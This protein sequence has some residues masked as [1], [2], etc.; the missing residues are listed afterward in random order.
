MSTSPPRAGRGRA[1]GR[2]VRVSRRA[3][4]WF[5]AAAFAVTMVGT[6]LPT[7]LYVLY[8]REMGFSTL[9]TTVVFAT[10]A[11]GVLAALLLFGRLSDAIGRRRTLLPGLA[12]A[13][14]SAVV[15]LAAHD[16]TL[17]LLGRLLSGLSAG[18]FTGTATAAL[19][20]LADDD[21][22]ERATLVSTV[23]NMGGL[24]TGPLLAGVLA[25][26]TAA[27]LITPFAV[28]LV[29]LVLAAAGI[30]LIPETVTTVGRPRLSFARPTVPR[31]MRGTF[32]RS[33]TAGFAGFAVLGLFTSVAPAFLGRLLHLSSPALAGAVVFTL[34]AASALGQIVLVRILGRT[35]LPVGCAMLIAGMGILAAALAAGSLALLLTAAVVAGLGQGTGFRA[36][37][38]SLNAQA[39]ADQR[40][41]VASTYFLVL[42]I[43]ISLPVTG[44]GLSADAFGLRDTGMAFS[45]A[46]ALL[47]LSVLLTLL[48][49]RRRSPSRHRSPSR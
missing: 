12:C 42:Y 9:M 40:A 46:V 27:P 20:D 45:A 8:Q 49:S 25:Q 41:A 3:A 2:R 43:A 30:W 39:P 15:F 31:R 26:T 37:L 4:F 33:A 36:G 6:T 11:V 47:A 10:Y 28:H 44:V 22:G 17:L 23:A 19:V 29:L 7:P 5:V 32:T 13:L 18:I 1:S 35:A 24:G 21:A 48:P 34:F 16:L 14:L 38:A